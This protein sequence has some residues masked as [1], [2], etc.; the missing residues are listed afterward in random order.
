MIK[1]SFLKR[2]PPHELNIVEIRRA[3]KTPC[4]PNLGIN[5]ILNRMFKT[6]DISVLKKIILLKL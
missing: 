3:N 5:N 6:K 2:I 1:R 4:N